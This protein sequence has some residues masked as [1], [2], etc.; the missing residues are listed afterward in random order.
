MSLLK[1]TILKIE[2]IDKVSM[3]KALERQDSLAKPLGSL[4]RLEELSIQL[5]G[6][7]KNYRVRSEKA[8]TVVFCSDNGVFE[9]GVSSCPQYVTL[10]QSINFVKGL[11]GISVLSR[12]SNADIRV[13][14]VGI[15]SDITFPGLINKKIR[16]GTFNMSKGSAMTRDE[17][18][19][20]IEIGIEAAEELISEGY[21]LLGTGEM[22]IGN[23]STSSAMLIG[24]TACD[25]NVAVGKGAGMTPEGYLLKKEVIM[26][27]IEINNPDSKDPL[28][29]L[30]K[31]G[32]FDIGGMAGVFLAAAKN[33]T[34]VVIDGFISSVAAL[35]AYRINKEVKNYMIPSHISEEPGYKLVMQIL[36]LEP[37]LNLRMRLGEG[38][39]CPL[40]FNIV[41]AAE[42]IINEMA[43]FQEAEIVDDYLIDIREK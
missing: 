18:I 22:G 10:T 32:G 28:D 4:G 3:E 33:R 41:R 29:V 25:I 7:R 5:A 19:K 14:D 35:L 26:K 11:T 2:P 6:I 38:T 13:F 9:E 31:V 20:S 27:A 24:F 43:T 1:N 21:N 40:A 34:P 8:C 37:I 23:T 16:K 17:A 12:A 36:G 39:G 30:S 15:N 42:S